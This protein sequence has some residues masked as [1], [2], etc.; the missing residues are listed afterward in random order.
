MSPGSPVSAASPAGDSLRSIVLNSSLSGM[1]VSTVPGTNGPITRTMLDRYAPKGTAYTDAANQEMA[2]GQLYGYERGWRDALG[3]NDVEVRLFHAATPAEAHNVLFALAEQ[4]LGS[5]I[6]FFP[7]P[8]VPGA[9]GRFATVEGPTG[10]PLT[11]IY[12]SFRRGDFAAEVE[13]V[14]ADGALTTADAAAL[15]AQQYRRIGTQP[16]TPPAGSGAGIFS[17]VGLVL[18]CV[19]GGLALLGLGVFVGRRSRRAP[20]MAAPGTVAP[21]PISPPSERRVRPVAP[22]ASA[23]DPGRTSAEPETSGDAE[24]APS[25]GARPDPVLEP[26]VRSEDS[27]SNWWNE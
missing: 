22:R 11:V 19:L 9:T 26:L 3:I 21:P 24:P 14:T 7:V 12:A 6:T 4:P 5:M 23:A 10:V 18:W 13:C 17:G 1:V 15:A 16:F 8:G 27:P 2:E 25:T 20:A